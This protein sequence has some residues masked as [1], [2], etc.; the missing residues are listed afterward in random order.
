MRTLQRVGHPGGTFI[1]EWYYFVV[2]TFAGAASEE[3]RGRN[4]APPADRNRIAG[5]TVRAQEFILLHE[6]GHNTDVLRPDKDNQA[7]IDANDKDLE[8]HCKKTINSFPK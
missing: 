4:D 7:L 8:T 5:G 2:H 6:L 3:R 1:T